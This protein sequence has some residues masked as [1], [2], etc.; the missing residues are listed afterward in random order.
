MADSKLVSDVQELLEFG[1]P[2]VT[3]RPLIVGA[4]M[5]LMANFTVWFPVDR[6]LAIP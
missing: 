6:F 1:A 2:K 5:F 4:A 3:L